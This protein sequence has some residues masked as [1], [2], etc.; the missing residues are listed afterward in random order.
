MTGGPFFP[1]FDRLPPDLPIFPLTGVLLL[2]RGLLP[3]NIFE[4][5]YLAMVDAALAT[6]RLIGMVQPVTP[7][8][9]GVEGAVAAPPVYRTGCA[10]RVTSFDETDDGRYLI[11][12][13]GVCRFHLGRESL[14]EGGYRMVEA[15]WSDF[16]ADFDAD[17]LTVDR[18]RLAAALNAFFKHHGISADWAAIGE[19]PDERLITSLAMICPFEPSEKQALLEAP[20]LADRAEMMVSLVEMAV[21]SRDGDH[22]ARH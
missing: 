4:P 21:L 11:T 12:L 10:G 8:G 7:G 3:L 20:T 18:E 2:P 1:I 19:A 16:A 13:T 14:A 6:D 5:R 9:P 22:P 17:E 15:G